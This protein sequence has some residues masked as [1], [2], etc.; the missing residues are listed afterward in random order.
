MDLTGVN[1]WS[2]EEFA[3]KE[4]AIAHA[5]SRRLVRVVKGA[6]DDEFDIIDD[7]AS[8]LAN[9]SFEVS[10]L[11]QLLAWMD[12]DYKLR[13]YLD[14]LI[15][16]AGS[17]EENEFTALNIEIA[18][19]IRTGKG[20]TSDDSMSKWV[21]RQKK[22]FQ[23]WQQA[24]NF[25][26][27]DIKDGSFNAKSRKN[28]PTTYKIH[29]LKWVKLAVKI[30]KTKDYWRNDKSYRRHQIK[31]IRNACYEV[32]QS[33]PDAP[34]LK[35][36]IRTLS[37]EEK[38]DRRVHL[39]ISAHLKNLDF[40]EKM[41]LAGEE[42]HEYILR[43]LDKAFKKERGVVGNL[44]TP[45]ADEPDVK[46]S[47]WNKLKDGTLLLEPV[48]DFEDA[49]EPKKPKYWSNGEWR[50]TSNSMT[51][52]AAP[53]NDSRTDIEADNVRDAENSDCN[54]NNLKTHGRTF[55]DENEVADDTNV[56]QPETDSEE[57]SD[58]EKRCA[59]YKKI[60]ADWTAEVRAKIPSATSNQRFSENGCWDVC[61]QMLA[62]IGGESD[63]RLTNAI[64]R[65]SEN[66]V[67]L[68]E[69]KEVFLDWI[70]LRLE[71]WRGGV[72]VGVDDETARK[73]R[74]RMSDYLKIPEADDG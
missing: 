25:N 62:T 46:S 4:S 53:E 66:K 65:A 20:N 55:L 32:W 9:T 67:Y 70:M 5:A 63:L 58:D 23:A 6:L 39:Q 61:W 8:D 26:L 57:I 27:V 29:I 2:T 71:R 3:E 48:E 44:L 45:D 38:F 47:V 14:A 28:T 15:G 11:N 16:I 40:V 37:E 74:A 73:F 33:I 34:P 49:V 50:E 36:K 21:T 12:F 24:N 17:S 30:A 72:P 19:Q 64:G 69:L 60:V 68:V 41:D 7:N 13:P 18:R 35:L 42:L 56:E 54:Y 43:E 59:P 31:A 51:E 22:A 52:K 10:A 1:E